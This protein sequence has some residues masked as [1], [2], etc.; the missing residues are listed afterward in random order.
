MRGDKAL[1]AA[2]N[3][4]ARHD[5]KQYI[6]LFIYIYIYIYIYI[7][8]VYILKGAL[9]Q[10]RRSRKV[11]RSSETYSNVYRNVKEMAT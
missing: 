10:F 11:E 2:R 6:V 5:P 9:C 7:I 8:D 1:H 4:A 3:V